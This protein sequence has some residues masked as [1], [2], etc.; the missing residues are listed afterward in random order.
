MNLGELQ[1]FAQSGQTGLKPCNKS[2]CLMVNHPINIRVIR[3]IGFT[4][5]HG[6]RLSD[7][8]N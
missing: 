8:N 7:P 4:I 5:K 1:Q 3:R 6:I 2:T